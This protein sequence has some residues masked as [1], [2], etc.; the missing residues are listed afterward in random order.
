MRAAMRAARQV[1]EGFL[2]GTKMENTK[3]TAPRAPFQI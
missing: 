2:F 3:Y 1:A